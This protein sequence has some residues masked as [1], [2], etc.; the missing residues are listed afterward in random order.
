MLASLQRGLSTLHCLLLHYLKSMTLVFFAFLLCWFLGDPWSCEWFVKS[1]TLSWYQ[2]PVWMECLARTLV[3]SLDLV[4]NGP[5]FFCK[6]CYLKHDLVS[7]SKRKDKMDVF[8]M[9]R[10]RM[11]APV[12]RPSSKEVDPVNPQNIHEFNELKYK[13]QSTILLT[14]GYKMTPNIFLGL[15]ERFNQM[16]MIRVFHNFLV[17]YLGCCLI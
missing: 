3:F 15:N 12:R 5:T 10:L 2:I 1:S 4:L 14:R 17:I 16:N 13:G 8:E 6:G 9:A 7:F 11:Q